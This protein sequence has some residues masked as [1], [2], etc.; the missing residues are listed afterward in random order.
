MAA[1]PPVNILGARQTDKGLIDKG[2]GLKS[3]V[4]S[5]RA[6]T[7]AGDPAQIRHQ[8]LKKS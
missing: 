3:V 4:W 8:Q 7:T 5:L 2:C 6:E 1:I